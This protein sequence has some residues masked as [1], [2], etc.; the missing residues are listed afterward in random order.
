MGSFGGYYF[1]DKK[2][3]SKKELEKR[4]KR[5]AQRQ[6]IEFKL[7]ELIKGKRE[8]SERS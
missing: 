2:K 6:P 8:K 5:L 3:F 1:G 7:P 4:A